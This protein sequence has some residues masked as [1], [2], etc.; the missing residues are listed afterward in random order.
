MG[1]GHLM[2]HSV[3]I[4]F[5]LDGGKLLFLRVDVESKRGVHGCLLESR[6]KSSNFVGGEDVMF[7]VSNSLWFSHDVVSSWF[8]CSAPK[9]ECGSDFDNQIACKWLI[10]Q[11]NLEGDTAKIFV[12]NGARFDR[13][14]NDTVMLG[15]FLLCYEYMAKN[16]Y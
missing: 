3:W 10:L 13:Q 9:Y 1:E 2:V 12:Y 8:T 16:A 15:G 7:T 6:L 4:S 14:R 5:D 11:T